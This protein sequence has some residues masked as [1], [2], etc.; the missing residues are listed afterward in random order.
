MAPTIR[1]GK[2][3]IIPLLALR[4][5]L[6]RRRSL[7]R[8]RICSDRPLGGRPAMFRGLLKL[9]LLIVVVVAAGAFLLGWWGGR[10][11]EPDRPAAAIGTTGADERARAAG[12]EAKE[13]TAQ[14]ADKTAAA[15]E[16]GKDRTV[17]AAKTAR[18][19][20]GPAAEAAKDRTAEAAQQARK[21]L[22]EGSLT[23]KIKA[24]M[25]L[26]DQVK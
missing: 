24:K 16:E 13:K 14:A 23:A 8:H 15:I 11:A 17:A 22:G 19:K 10:V 6:S 20:L 26:D 7:H 3:P 4:K 21:A 9:L 12:A 25:A 5:L 18:E 2:L 1:S